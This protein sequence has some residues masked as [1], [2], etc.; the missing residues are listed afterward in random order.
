MKR[1]ELTREYGKITIQKYNGL[2]GSSFIYVTDEEMNK[3]IQ[4][5]NKIK[6]NEEK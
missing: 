4:D 2:G 5:Y 1:V 6:E 3:L